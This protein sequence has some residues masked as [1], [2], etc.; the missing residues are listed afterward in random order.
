MIRQ[1]SI[2][3]SKSQAARAFTLVEMLIVAALIALFAGLAVYNIQTQLT[4]N[5]QK[6]AVAECRQIA[7]AM[8]FAHDDVGFYPRISLLRFNYDML[9]RELFGCGFDAAEYYGNS[10]GGLNNRLSTQWK[11]I[12]L[13]FNFER[14]GKMQ[15]KSYVN[16]GSVVQRELDWP[17]DPWNTPYVAYLM[18]TKPATV[19]GGAP[20][21][22]FLPSVKDKAD[23]FAGIVSYGPNRVPGLGLNA[24]PAQV[25][26]RKP[27]RLFYE[28]PDTFNTFSSYTPKQLDAAK[29]NM[30]RVDLP[31]DPI[32]P[33]IREVGSD[34]RV[35]EF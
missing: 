25:E 2:V 1:T 31:V 13:A 3:G 26:A 14:V 10:V 6:A 16:G 20:D 5:K 21:C 23:Y 27:L 18:H 7:S 11:G 22:E 32:N 12:Y 17:L 19:S 35:L 30:I 28:P 34:D 29:A 33:R 24:T 9:R 15:F 4:L 8:A